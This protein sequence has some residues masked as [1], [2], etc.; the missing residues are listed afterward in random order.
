M[1][2]YRVYFHKKENAPQVWSVDEGSQDTEIHVQR[3]SF[4]NCNVWTNTN[5][6]AQPSQPS[7][8]LEVLAQRMEL[9]GG[10]V[11]FYGE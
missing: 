9:S 4:V 8:W 5:R 10:C 2:L 3:V 6:E 7:G 11:T 1:M